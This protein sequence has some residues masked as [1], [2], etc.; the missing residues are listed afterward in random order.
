MKIKGF[1]KTKYLW[2]A[3]IVMAA[4]V[5]M[6][7]R[8]ITPSFTAVF[9]L[10]PLMLVTPKKP[11]ISFVLAIL[12]Y[13]LCMWN[14]TFSPLYPVHDS[15]LFHYTSFEYIAQSFKNGQFFV[16]FLPVTGGAKLGI[17]HINLFPYTPFRIAGYMLAAAGLPV[18]TAYKLQYLFCMLF[19]ALGFW[20]CLLKATKNAKVSYVALILLM[21][22]G[23]SL[24][25]RIEQAAV[26]FHLMPW[27]LYCLLKAKDSAA[28]FV[29]AAIFLFIGSVTHYPQIQLIA[30]LIITAAVLLYN[31]K[32]IKNIKLLNKNSAAL[33]ILSALL[34]GVAALY[35]VNNSSLQSSPIR[36][37]AQL[38]PGNYEEYLGF[39][40][41]QNMASSSPKRLKG[42]FSKTFSMGNLDN[43]LFKTINLTPVFALLALI[44]CRK[45]ALPLFAVFILFVLLSF[46]INF[47]IAKLLFYIKF[48]FIDIFR[49]WF[50]FYGF[51]QMALVML[52]A[53]GLKLWVKS[54]NKKNAAVLCLI[55]VTIFVV[56]DGAT[57][58]KNYVRLTQTDLE[59]IAL[60]ENFFSTCN[61][62]SNIMQY[63][64]RWELLSAAPLVLHNTAFAAEGL[65]SNISG[66]KEQ[67]LHIGREF[68]QSRYI[69]VTDYPVQMLNANYY[70][71][72][73]VFKREGNV[74]V[75]DGIISVFGN[76]PYIKILVDG[77]E[78]RRIRMEQFCNMTVLDIPNGDHHLAVNYPQI[79]RQ[80]PLQTYFDKEVLTAVKEQEEEAFVV[81]PL[82]Y[83]L[84]F[85]VFIDGIPARYF[86]TDSA[87]IGLPVP[88][89]KRIITAKPPFD[90]SYLTAV[91]SCNILYL[92]ALFILGYLL[93]CGD[94]Q[95]V[96]KVVTGI[97]ADR[98]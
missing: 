54:F 43:S 89:G 45:A 34:A 4:A 30:A 85:N 42:A 79:N 55:G 12:P 19:A 88:E 84:G 52:A 51:A 58:F 97:S 59:G 31:S 18:V 3:L 17:F 64:A 65:I 50:L 2:A 68:G 71:A 27:F 32:T 6:F 13:V 44:F 77:K 39:A 15:M 11:F 76:H 25:M 60:E 49:Q 29:P 22:S 5:L 21:L 37:A 53:M 81:L 70:S 61:P 33:I 95:F 40:G 94:K 57:S 75:K 74:T 67:L 35:V 98:R 62:I 73:G 14:Y 91:I 96:R 93:K 83:D 56:L 24:T 8:L 7:P 23:F 86:R 92:A 38:R 72:Y 28:Y 1:V 26:T 80:K 9:A 16:D 20:L 87:F 82:N 66:Y 48:P 78:P 90:A 63:P 41:L 69:T 46:G 47:P 36:N 10:L